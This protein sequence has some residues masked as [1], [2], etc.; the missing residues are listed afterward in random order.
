MAG[1]IY[2][3]DLDKTQA[4][5]QPQT[6]LSY[7]DWAAS[8]YPNKTA[9]IHGDKTYTYTEFRDR[10]VRLASA[11]HRRGVGLGDTVSLCRRMALQC[12]KRIT[13]FPWWALY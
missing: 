5:F 6:P 11:L 1:N 13:E 9:V 4:N 12:L 3:Q 7:L 10:C 2:T 8:V